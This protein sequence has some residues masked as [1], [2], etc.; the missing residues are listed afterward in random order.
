MIE[1][2]G[3][4][5]RR[6]REEGEVRAERARLYALKMNLPVPVQADSPDPALRVEVATD[7]KDEARDCIKMN[8]RADSVSRGGQSLA[9]RQERWRQKN[10]PKRAAYM[11]RYRLRQKEIA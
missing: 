8:A 4:V 3:D 6:L 5:E 1:L 9:E 2:K 7:S 11:K 10:K